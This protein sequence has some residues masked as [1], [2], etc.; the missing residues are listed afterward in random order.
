MF[1]FDDVIMHGVYMGIIAT[2][3]FLSMAHGFIVLYFVVI[4]YQVRVDMRG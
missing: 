3:D 2:G 4:I 1:P